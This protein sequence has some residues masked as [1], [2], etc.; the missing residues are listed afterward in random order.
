MLIIGIMITGCRM[1]VFLQ[2]I[3]ERTKIFMFVVSKIDERRKTRVERK[4]SFLTQ[5]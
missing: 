3:V 4:M 5:L 1:K 2:T